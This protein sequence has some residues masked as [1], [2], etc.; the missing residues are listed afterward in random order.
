MDIAIVGGVMNQL[1]ISGRHHSEGL[2]NFNPFALL[3][4][5]WDPRDDAQARHIVVAG[6]ISYMNP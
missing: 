1:A 5:C 6:R 4:K 2:I 3:Q